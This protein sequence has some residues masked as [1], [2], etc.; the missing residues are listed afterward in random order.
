MCCIL[1]VNC[2]GEFKNPADE[3]MAPVREW[4]ERQN[5]KFVYAGTRKFRKD[6][7]KE[8]H[9]KLIRTWKR[10]GKL[11]TVDAGKVEK[12]TATLEGQIRSDDPHIIALARVANVKMLISHDRDLHDDFTNR[13]LIQGGKIYQNK[14][15][16]H[17]LTP[18]LCP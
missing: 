9:Q 13:K 15:H 4:H 3:N 8:N 16:R 14:S 11:K 2:L 7:E 5:G 17:L 18:D 1:D 6:W 12:E 10:R